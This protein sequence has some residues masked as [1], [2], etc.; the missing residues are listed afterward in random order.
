MVPVYMLILGWGNQPERLIASNYLLMY[1]LCF[2][3]P[4]LSAVMY[5]TT[6]NF[7]IWDYVLN[8]DF[9]WLFILALVMPFFVKIPVYMLHLWLPKAHVEAP[10][11]GSMF[12]ASIL[13]KTGVYGLMKINGIFFKN[14][15]NS[16]ITV[17][18]IMILSAS[19]MCFM[20]NDLKKF[21]AF[22]SVAHMTMSINLMF[23]NFTS[24]DSGMIILMLSHG[25]LSNIMFY[26]TGMLSN[27]SKTRVIHMQ[28]NILLMLPGLWFMIIVILFFNSGL[29]PS[30][31]MT[32]EIMM[33]I[34][35]YMS[36]KINLLILCVLFL[37]LIYYPVWM[38][39][40]MNKFNQFMKLLTSMLISDMMILLFYM[41]SLILLWWNFSIML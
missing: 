36:W 35:S 17:S 34:N 9:S 11:M 15:D 20:Q 3:L 31:N 27:S 14:Y 24:M 7:T 12:L 39:T 29:P 13:L 6:N 18:L 41:F 33:F 38:M 22:S 30:I 23:S 28:Q 19:I 8:Y 16:M 21:V 40:M 26:F 25:F 32:S 2:S 5:L 4:M 10:V 1:T 37:T